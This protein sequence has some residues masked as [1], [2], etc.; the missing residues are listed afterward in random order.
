MTAAEKYDGLVESYQANVYMRTYVE[1]IK[2]N[3]LYKYARYIP[4][5][6]LCDEKTDEA[7]IETISKLRFVEP[8]T[9][10]QDIKYVT[11]TLTDKKDI[12][13]LPFNFLAIDVYGET[14]YD[15]NFVMPLRFNSSKYYHYELDKTFTENNKTY[16]KI[17]FTPIYKS[18][19]FLKGYCIIENGT[20]RVIEF[21][22]EGIDI[23]SEYSFD[24]VMGKDHDTEY[25]P[26]DITIYKT[27]SYLGNKVASRYL[28]KI[29]YEKIIFKKTTEKVNQLNISDIYKIRM[30]SVPIRNDSL[31]WQKNRLIP[32]Q[33]KEKDVIENFKDRMVEENSKNVS[34]TTNNMQAGEIAQLM[35]LDSQYKYK[36]TQIHYGGLFNPFL[37]GYSSYDGLT[38]R[39]SLSLNID[40]NYYR[41]L[42]IDA[43]AGYMFKR[44]ELV[45]DASFKWNYNPRH[46]GN[47]NFSVGK[48][49]KTFSSSFI[50]MVQDSLDHHGLSFA[51]VAV[52]YFSDYYIRLFN[53]VEYV[54]GLLLG[55]GAEYHIR[56]SDSNTSMLRSASESDE[57]DEMFKTRYYFM[58][59]IRISWTPKQYYRMEGRQKIPVRSNYP[60]FKLMIAK[61]FDNI[62]GSTSKFDRYELDISQ[63]IQFGLLKSLQYHVGGGMF[64]N[65]KTEYFAEF[66]Y[67]SKYNFPDN[68]DDGIGGNFNLLQRDLYNISES[69]FQLH[70]LYKTPSLLLRNIPLISQGILTERLYLSQ[71]YTPQIHSYSEIGYGIGNRFFNAGVFGSFHK[72]SFHQIGIKAALAF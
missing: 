59:F 10:V 60:T 47:L 22:A 62:L 64:S 70:V 4:K 30:D 31:F 52:N 14:T 1:T 34:D 48:G 29:N 49:N 54:N 63:N 3:F 17:V 28:A 38:Y 46:L 61:S 26:V 51:D 33:A 23:M 69:Y 8:N 42:K 7:V 15:E 65:Q 43:Y 58:P 45:A 11:G 27:L 72:F 39:Q 44:K 41:S 21:K 2:K 71:L 20:W 50:Q 13:M 36:S 56:K 5:F 9:Y 25:L 37:I 18:Q 24:I 68:W 19:A 6:V 16:Y 53:D 35:T 57:I 66:V 55:A 12:E 32:L 40:L 67:F